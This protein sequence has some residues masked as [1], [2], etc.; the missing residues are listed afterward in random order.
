MAPIHFGFLMI[1]YQALD[2][3]GPLD[4]LSSCS[5][6]YI[7]EMEAHGVPKG[8]SEKAPEIVFHHIGLTMEAVKLTGNYHVQPTTT[9]DKCPPLDY[10]LV[11][12]PKP[13]Y[14]LPPEFA[15]FLQTRVKEV[16][17]LFSTCTGGMVLAAAGLLD[18]RNATTNHG[19]VPAARE[20]FPKVKWTT[21]RQWVVDGNLW[22]A[23]GA[24][25][26]M[27]AMAEWVV[28]N[29]G[30]DVAEAGFSA[31]DYERRDV[32]GKRVPLKKF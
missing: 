26:G 27:D 6:E 18:G 14:Q 7:K 2:V 13:D 10:L 24:C 25:A 28:S 4:V 21:E 32:E 17:V 16:K 9:Y 8:I 1:P 22:T 29:Y 11:G 31:L 5:A 12:G 23:G 15:K 3:V 19:V 30:E 20:I